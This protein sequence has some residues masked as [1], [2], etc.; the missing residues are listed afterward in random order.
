MRSQLENRGMSAL[1]KAL[2]NVT[3][4]I[5][6]LVIVAIFS[7]LSP[8]FFRPINF[9]TIGMAAATLGIVAIGQSLILITGN[10]DLSVGQNVALSGVLT[11]MLSRAGLP[12][13]YI[14]PII[15]LL[16]VT[17]GAINASLITKAKINAFIV[18]L[19]MLTILQGIVY[20][21]T[22][23]EYISSAAAD[24]RV[25]GKEPR[26]II[27][28]L[29]LYAVF[30]IIMRYSVFGRYVYAIGGNKDSA[31]LSGIN[32]DK[33]LFAV[34]M[35]SGFLAA[36]SGISL[37][38]RLG[39]ASTG[40]GLSYPLDSIAASV[41]GGISLAGGRGNILF[42]LIGVLIIASVSNG[43]IIVG[44][45]SSYQYLATGIILILAVLTDSLKARRA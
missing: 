24:F 34:Y 12:F 38:S 40:I 30:Y 8:Q 11:A 31:R 43:L 41:I 39:A 3:I 28:I 29:V 35:L 22:G 45:P 23:G 37:A 6:F 4:V 15:L 5:A 10:F 44:V 17:I 19:G 33:Y 18:T 32:I 14:V 36:F 25:I 1:W 21:V 42:T 26:P 16:G 27:Y 7:I 13:V 9:I 2:N 20:V